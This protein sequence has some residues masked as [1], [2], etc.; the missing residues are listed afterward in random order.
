MP[1]IP[2]LSVRQ[3]WA[4]AILLGKDVENR[5][6]RFKYRG[7]LLI[8]AAMHT[9]A[10]NWKDPRIEALKLDR[11]REPIGCLIGLVTLVDC[12]RD[13]SSIWADQDSW[14]LVLRDPVRLARPVLF[15]GQ[16]NLFKIPVHLIEHLLPGSV[17]DAAQAT[18]AL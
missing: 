18:L 10:H 13:S 2:A 12:V 6:R 16:L 15:K 5:S 14:H 8:H 4:S 3:P 17:L 1:S 9:S 7:P 11:K